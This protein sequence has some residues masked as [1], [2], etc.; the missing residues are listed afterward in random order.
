MGKQKRAKLFI[1]MNTITYTILYFILYFVKVQ[2]NPSLRLET[3]GALNDFGT[4]A[5]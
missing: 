5:S 1:I 3:I 2:V 4:V